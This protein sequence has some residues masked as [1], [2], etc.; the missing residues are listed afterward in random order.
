MV[1]FLFTSHFQKRYE[2]EN[3]V[4]ISR[5]E[6]RF[7]SIPVGP[8]DKESLDNIV[9]Q[10]YVQGMIS[11]D[12][13]KKSINSGT[14]HFT[15]RSG[16]IGIT[17]HLDSMEKRIKSIELERFDINAKFVFLDSDENECFSTALLV[18]NISSAE[19]MCNIYPEKCFSDEKLEDEI[20]IFENRVET[21]QEYLECEGDPAVRETLVS[22]LV[23]YRQ[24]LRQLLAEKDRRKVQH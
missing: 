10:V 16:C 20:D 15:D 1:N 21:A 7:Q 19:E 17:Y 18:G 13:V 9:V 23:S 4:S 5:A 14:Y 6:Y 22:R 11:F 3:L 24:T 2:N 12:A 8:G